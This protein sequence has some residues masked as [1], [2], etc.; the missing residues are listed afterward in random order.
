MTGDFGRGGTCPLI[1]YGEERLNAHAV[2]NILFAQNQRYA[3]KV[4]LRDE[5]AVATSAVVHVG[6]FRNVCFDALA[7]KCALGFHCLCDRAEQKKIVLHV[8]QGAEEAFAAPFPSFRLICVPPACFH[9]Q[10]INRICK[11][12]VD[13][14][15]KKPLDYR[16]LEK[17]VIQ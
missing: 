2:G 8:I 13:V 12:S 9:G 4:S 14:C 11:K 3:Q 16:H 5:Q 17:N 10:Y 6:S 7:C 1:R 15:E